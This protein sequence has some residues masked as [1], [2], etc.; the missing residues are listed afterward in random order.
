MWKSEFPHCVPSKPCEKLTNVTVNRE[1]KMDVKYEMVVKKKNGKSFIPNGK[2][3]RFSCTKINETRLKITYKTNSSNS[4]STNRYS[5]KGMSQIICKNGEWIGLQSANPNCITVPKPKIAMAN[6]QT[7]KANISDVSEEISL[8][9]RVI[10]I[11]SALFILLCLIIVSLL[12]Y[13][14]KFKKKLNR[15]NS[16]KANSHFN[17][18]DHDSPIPSITYNTQF[19]EYS[20]AI[21]SSEED[22]FHRDNFEPEGDSHVY[23]TVKLNNYSD[24]S[25]SEVKINEFSKIGEERVN[26][27]YGL[28]DIDF[29]ECDEKHLFSD[30][31]YNELSRVSSVS[32]IK[33]SI[34]ESDNKTE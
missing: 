27:I 22:F 4:T 18:F 31:H 21:Y 29:D 19:N 10:Q 16:M 1:Y 14:I 15:A 24:S 2:Y 8:P 7:Q 6:L 11:L 26:S 28:E 9:V 23:Y 33:N 25:Y 3:A 12:L 13:M 5:H 17:P 20:D 34:Y 30:T 32:M